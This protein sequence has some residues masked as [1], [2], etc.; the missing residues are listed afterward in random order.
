MKM[1]INTL[2]LCCI[3]GIPGIRIC[4]EVHAAFQCYYT[5]MKEKKNKNIINIIKNE[6]ALLLC[7][8]TSIPI[9]YC[10]IFADEI[11]KFLTTTEFQKENKWEYNHNGIIF[12]VC[13][14]KKAFFKKFPCGC[15]N[16]EYTKSMEDGERKI[17]ER[18]ILCRMRGARE[19]NKTCSSEKI[20]DDCKKEDAV[21]KTCVICKKISDKRLLCC[22]CK[23]V[24]YCSSE[25][26]KKDWKSHKK[27][28]SHN[29]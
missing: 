9:E 21:A 28:C 6:Y 7:S 20:C 14:T 17:H 3:C 5:V 12:T 27:T 26:Q 18:R 29:K 24:R 25:C 10:I 1:S 11:F 13:A 23:T 16:D 15:D 8:Y 4:E 2:W 19:G 22:P